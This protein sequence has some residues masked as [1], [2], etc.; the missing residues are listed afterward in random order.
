MIVVRRPAVYACFRPRREM[1]QMSFDEINPRSE[2]LTDPQRHEELSRL[3][4]SYRV[5]MNQLTGRLLFLERQYRRKSDA[6]TEVVGTFCDSFL[7]SCVDIPDKPEQWNGEKAY[8]SSYVFVCAK[9]MYYAARDLRA[10]AKKIV[11]VRRHFYR[12]LKVLDE[13]H[14]LGISAFRRGGLLLEDRRQFTG[15][16]RETIWKRCDKTCRYCGKHIPSWHGFDMHI[17][18]ITP[19]IAGGS[20]ETENLCAACPDCNLKKGA[21]NED[22]FLAALLAGRGSIVTDGVFHSKESLE[23]T[24]A[25]PLPTDDATNEAT[26]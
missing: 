13:Q 23:E 4:A 2:K 18:H 8:G 21:K 19:I 10:V 22:A 11:T 9:E 15:K 25:S 14:K 5:L 3:I 16:E 7:Q 1:T 26:D 12:D 17:D 20:D 24:L 6:A